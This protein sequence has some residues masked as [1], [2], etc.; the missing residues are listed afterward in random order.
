MTQLKQ[1]LKA[2]KNTD[3]NAL[4]EI[5]DDDKSYMEVSKYLFVDALKKELQGQIDDG[6]SGFDEI[7]ENNNGSYMFYTKGYPYLNLYF[8]LD[9]KEILDIFLSHDDP[10]MSEEEY[11]GEIYFFF[12]EEDK[13][14]FSPDLKYLLNKQKAEKAVTDFKILSEKPYIYIEDI[15]Y[16]RIKY[17]D[18]VS[19]LGFNPPIDIEVYRAF[20]EVDEI[21]R[22]VYNTT[23]FIDNH[24]YAKEA[25]NEYGNLNL[26]EEKE[27]VYWLLTHKN[28]Q[29]HF[30]NLGPTNWQTT[31]IIKLDAD[32]EMFVDCSTY[33]DSFLFA[34]LYDRLENNLIE[35]YMP[36]KKY[37]QEHKNG[38]EMSL[39]SH[40]KIHNKYLDILP[41]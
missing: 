8:K 34:E 12:Y 20:L 29:L 1:A 37:Y 9:D 5:L 2:I 11:Y 23:A 28:N 6:F 4:E 13:E 40:L 7:V 14:N 3:F 30:F 17:E 18:I 10:F 19:D 32:F 27:I 41:E 25:L 31:G 38:I 33:I 24:E 22:V 36:T 26:N 15:D 21:C 39:E 16:W 35:K